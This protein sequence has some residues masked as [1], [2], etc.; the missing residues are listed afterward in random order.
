MDLFGAAHGSCNHKTWNKYTLPK[1]D[2]TPCVL[3]TSVFFYRRLANF[4][5]DLLKIQVF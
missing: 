4:A 5:I 2:D 3:L 1:E